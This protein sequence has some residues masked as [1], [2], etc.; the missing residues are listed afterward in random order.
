MAIPLTCD[1]FTDSRWETDIWPI[2]IQVH[3]P[4]TRHVSTSD[5]CLWN[6][7]VVGTGWIPWECDY[8][9]RIFNDF[10]FEPATSRT[11]RLKSY[12]Y[13][14]FPGL[15]WY[16]I[17]FLLCFVPIP[18]HFVHWVINGEKTKAVLAYCHLESHQKPRDTSFNSVGMLFRDFFTGIDT[19]RAAGIT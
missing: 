17:Y 9:W 10:G 2:F 13:T 12:G 11:R 14:V 5:K 15:D 8:E 16:K 6:T 19:V 1:T 7:P 4:T 18:Q 3:V